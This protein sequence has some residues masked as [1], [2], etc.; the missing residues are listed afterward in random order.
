MDEEIF[1]EQTDTN[2]IIKCFQERSL[3]DDVNN[4][5]CVIS[6]NSPA[7]LGLNGSAAASE[8]HLTLSARTMDDIAIAWIEKR[9]GISYD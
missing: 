1:F 2:T 3:F 9:K 4:N 7:P 5:D 8:V 6:L